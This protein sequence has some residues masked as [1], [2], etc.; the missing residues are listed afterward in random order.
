MVDRAGAAYMIIRS[1]ATTDD[2]LVKVTSPAASVVEM[3]QTTAD[4]SGMMVMQ[5]VPEIP[6]PAD[7]MVALAPG[8]YHLMLIDLVAP[9]V[10]GTDVELTLTFR[11]GAVLAVHAL[12]GT[13]APTGSP[14]PMATMAPMGSRAPLMSTAPAASMMP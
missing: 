9:L 2:A 6:V 13:G 5:P 4:P 3:H 14:S 1:S 11:S 12:V 8:G 7:G 10:D